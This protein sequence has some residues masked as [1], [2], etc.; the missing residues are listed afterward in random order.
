LLREAELTG[1]MPWQKT[2]W[3]PA[4]AETSPNPGD[5]KTEYEGIPADSD[6]FAAGRFL[7]GAIGSGG[8]VFVLSTWSRGKTAEELR[9][10]FW[11][12]KPFCFFLLLIGFMLLYQPVKYF[13]TDLP[14]FIWFPV[15][16]L[17]VTI[18]VLLSR[19]TAPVF[20][21][22]PLLAA[23]YFGGRAAYRFRLRK[24]AADGAPSAGG[25]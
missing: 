15:S 12:R 5:T 20:W 10:W 4:A 8:R 6:L 16:F 18:L 17:A 25:Q 3:Q 14:M 2:V 13:R 24:K 21:L 1:N 23:L 19:H 7:D 9:P 22:A 11:F